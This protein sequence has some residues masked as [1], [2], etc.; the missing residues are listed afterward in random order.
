MGMPKLLAAASDWPAARG[1]CA[2]LCAEL[3]DGRW[4]S[5]EELKATYPYASWRDGRAS[6]SIDD[7]LRAV[8]A[9][10]FHRGIAMIESV[11]RTTSSTHDATTTPR[12]S[13]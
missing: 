9:F 12:R 11:T 6:I 7:S 10:N 5:A 2:A 3:E 1:A 4:N 13:A 8:V